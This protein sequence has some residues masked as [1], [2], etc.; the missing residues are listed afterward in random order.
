MT[1]S[2]T[3]A[4]SL[5]ERPRGCCDLSGRLPEWSPLLGVVLRCGL[6][7]WATLF[8]SNAGGTLFAQL[9]QPEFTVSAPTEDFFYDPADPLAT[10]TLTFTIEQT[11]TPLEGSIGFSMS[12]SQVGPI[13][14]LSIE[15]LYINIAFSG[16]VFLK[17]RSPEK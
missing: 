7:F 9:S 15:P 5:R 1:P 10:Q 8:C 11:N 6:L 17:E 2:T 3:S 14:P 4:S 12:V 16:K 13:E